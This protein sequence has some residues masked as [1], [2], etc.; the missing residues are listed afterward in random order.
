MGTR[1]KDTWTHSTL[2]P[3]SGSGQPNKQQKLPV[4]DNYSTMP[5]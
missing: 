3:A 5:Q 2:T 4:V 1:Q